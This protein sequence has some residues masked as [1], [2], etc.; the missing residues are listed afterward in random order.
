MPQEAAQEKTKKKKERK[1]ESTE[2]NR[3]NVSKG[4]LGSSPS[5]VTYERPV[6]SHLTS[7]T[8][9]FLTDKWEFLLGS[10]HSRILLCSSA[11]R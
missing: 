10:Y 5:S 11:H 8:L 4:A 3:G 9:S 2:E 7:L 6:A 1:K